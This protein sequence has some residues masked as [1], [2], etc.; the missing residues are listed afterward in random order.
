M[1]NLAMHASESRIS[2]LIG[3]CFHS[4]SPRQTDGFVPR[5][6]LSLVP[7]LTFDLPSRAMVLTAA[8]RN[9]NS[10]YSPE[11]LAG[12][13]P[14]ELTEM[15]RAEKGDVMTEVERLQMQTAAQHGA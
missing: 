13:S 5:L 4:V 10:G 15:L 1:L 7:M 3:R 9:R 2:P 11:E 6:S 12:Q 14:E 8:P